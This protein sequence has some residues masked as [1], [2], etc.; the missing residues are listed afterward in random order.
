MKP[1]DP[2]LLRYSRKSRGFV[3]LAVLI[4]LCTAALAIVIAWSLAGVITGRHLITVLIIGFLLRASL[5]LINQRVATSFSIKIRNE[6]RVALLHRILKG[7]SEQVKEIG[8]AGVSLLLTRG[9]SNLD[10]Y[11]AK[12]IPQLFIGVVLPITIGTAITIVDWRS[13]LIILLTIP[14]LPLFGI[15]IGKFTASAADKKMSTLNFLGTYFLDLITGLPTLKVYGRSKLQ[16]KKLLEIG[17]RYRVETM[18]VLKIAFLSSLALELVA[19]LSVALLA[20][21]IGLRLADGEMSLH[22]GLFILVLAPEVY[23]PIRQVS[24]LFHSVSDGVAVSDQIFAI[25]AEPTHEG[26]LQVGR[27]KAIAWSELT[28]RYPDRSVIVIAPG[29]LLPG[30]VTALVG[31]SG[32]GKSTLISLLLGV[33][34]PSSG[35]IRVTTEQGTFDYKDLDQRLLQSQLSWLPQLPHLSAGTIRDYVGDTNLLAGIGLL[36][37][38]L[39][40]GFAAQ[41]GSMSDQLSYGQ[42]RKLALARAL[43]K[44]SVVL[45]VDEPTASMDPDSEAAITKTLELEALKGKIVLVASHRPGTISG[46][47]SEIVLEVAR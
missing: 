24:A 30:R 3:F 38:D 46:A 25:L 40:G 7:Q 16:K 26:G 18:K 20:I 19:T 23:W 27:I 8:P 17:G 14:L 47:A 44:H 41:I 11:F 1:L 36:E 39:P 34:R 2:R 35:W 22:T 12:F 42:K 21:S 10:G 31:A 15:I 33:R 5:L 9:I 37:R 29:E 13:G 45:L 6:L 43:S 32:T 4:A 28:V